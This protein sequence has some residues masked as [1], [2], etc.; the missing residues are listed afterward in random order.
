MNITTETRIVIPLSQKSEITVVI[1]SSKDRIHTLEQ[2]SWLKEFRVVV[3]RNNLGLSRAYNDCF[4]RAKTD[5]VVLLNDD[6]L[7]DP[8]VRRYFS[9]ADGEFA[10]LE[11]G[12]FPVSGITVIRRRDLWRVGGFNESLK[13]GSA[14][15]EFFCRATLKGLKYKPIP[16]SLVKHFTHATRYSTIYKSFHA[17]S[18]NVTCITRYFIHFPGLFLKHDFL[19][20]V[21]RRQFKSI[22]L[23][24]FFFFKITLFDKLLMLKK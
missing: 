6:L 1:P 14:D 17:I 20:R 7:I 22:L 13:Y 10:M 12:D 4:R 8:Q 19:L 18:D 23:H 24:L 5:T 16:L 9:V 15:R 2:N 11:T 21:L 3:V